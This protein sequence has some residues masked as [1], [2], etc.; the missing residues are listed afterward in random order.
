MGATCPANLDPIYRYNLH[1]ETMSL[2]P[3][4]LWTINIYQARLSSPTKRIEKEKKICLKSTLSLHV[5]CVWN[6]NYFQLWAS[7]KS[8]FLSQFVAD[9]W[10][11]IFRQT[12]FN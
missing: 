5:C 8:V 10:L 12:M 2:T 4:C 6:A 9:N 11:K 1:S 3:K 7:W